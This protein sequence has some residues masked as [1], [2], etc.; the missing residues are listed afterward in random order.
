MRRRILSILRWF[1]AQNWF[2]GSGGWHGFPHHYFNQDGSYLYQDVSTIDWAICAAGIRVA[3]QFYSQNQELVAIAT[4]LLE[5]TQWEKSIGDD[6]RIA[7]GFDGKTGNINDY[8]WGLAFS[9]ETELVYLEA[10]ASGRVSSEVL[11]LIIRNKKQGFYPSWFGAGFTYNW[12]QLWTGP[13][14]PYAGNSRMAFE[15]DANTCDSKFE[16]QLM[17]FNCLSDHVRY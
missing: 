6:G 5:R 7:M 9:E 1:Q 14:E 8:R 2:D 11:D 15:Y 10:L 17:G 3:R 13:I 16:K 12:L 4:E